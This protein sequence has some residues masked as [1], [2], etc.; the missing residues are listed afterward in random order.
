MQTS[1][2]NQN[3]ALLRRPKARFIE[4]F[5]S[6]WRQV[7]NKTMFFGLLA[8]TFLAFIAEFYQRRLS[9]AYA[10]EQRLQL[11]ILTVLP[12]RE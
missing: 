4:E 7:P 12:D 8:G 10:I 1:E 2:Q 11:P 9:N 5:S 6:I 3:G